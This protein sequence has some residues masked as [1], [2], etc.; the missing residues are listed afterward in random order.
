MWPGSAKERST[1]YRD[2]A[3][4]GTMEMT[5]ITDWKRQ[6]CAARCN[7]KWPNFSALYG[8]AANVRRRREKKQWGLLRRFEMDGAA[9]QSANR[10]HIVLRGA[11][12]HYTAIRCAAPH[13][14]VSASHSAQKHSLTLKNF[15]K[16]PAAT[17]RR[18]TPR[19]AQNRSRRARR[20]NAAAARRQSLR[21]APRLE[22]LRAPHAVTCYAVPRC[23]T[24][25]GGLRQFSLSCHHQ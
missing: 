18:T 1:E 4:D 16:R 19:N 14:D 3:K 2:D 20:R 23:V 15:Q 11:A 13:S 22:L 25:T 8:S 12:L 17:E 5:W 24:V 6:R 7:K 21:S 9:L 10:R